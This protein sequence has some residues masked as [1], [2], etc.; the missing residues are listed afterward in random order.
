MSLEI[1]I[2]Q[3]T[4]RFEI[5][6][7]ISLVTTGY[8]RQTDKQ[9]FIEAKRLNSEGRSTEFELK[10][11]DVYKEMGIRGYEFGERFQCIELTDLEGLYQSLHGNIY[12]VLLTNECT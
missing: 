6:E 11:M 2:S 10:R 12:D 5:Y 8:I 3:S 4:G 1:N 9:S 7:G